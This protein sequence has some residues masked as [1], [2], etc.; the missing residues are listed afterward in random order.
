VELVNGTR[1]AC[2]LLFAHPAQHQCE[3]VRT[4]G[5][6]LDEDGFV[7]VD[8][9]SRQTSVPGMFAA[10]DLTTRMQAAIAAAASG[11]QAAAMINMELTVERVS[12]R[13][14]E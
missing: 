10:G 7:Q 1:V 8:P 13:S 12:T 11:M 5:V 9:M 4:L 3:L 2:E 14:L 6:A